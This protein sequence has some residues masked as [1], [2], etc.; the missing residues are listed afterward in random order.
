MRFVKLSSKFQNRREAVVVTAC[1]AWAGKI[2]TGLSATIVSQGKRSQGGS[3]DMAIEAPFV[4][5]S[6]SHPMMNSAKER[7]PF[8]QM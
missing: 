8:I 1:A 7:T 5:V 2:G 4:L 6:A 3:Q